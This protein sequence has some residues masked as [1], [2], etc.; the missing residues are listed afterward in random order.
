MVYRALLLPWLLIMHAKVASQP[1]RKEIRYK[2]RKAV[3]HYSKQFWLQL[4]SFAATQIK[5]KRAYDGRK[6][7]GGANLTPKRVL[8]EVRL[9]E[10]ELGGLEVGGEVRCGEHFKEGQIVDVIG[11]TKGRGFTGVVKRHGF[12]TRVQ[13][14]GTHE[15]VPNKESGI[16]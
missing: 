5:G 14:H 8:F 4:K 15:Y 16:A 1:W 11:R 7:M 9:P 13:T 3:R 10:S 6:V 2:T 12:P